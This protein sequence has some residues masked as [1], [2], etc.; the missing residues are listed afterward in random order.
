MIKTKHKDRF[1]LISVL[2]IGITGQEEEGRG[3]VGPLEK[4][5]IKIYN[6]ITQMYVTLKYM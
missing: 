4:N 6:K 5:I 1:K 2:D 3:G